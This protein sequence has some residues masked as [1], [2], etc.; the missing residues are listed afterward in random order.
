MHYRISAYATMPLQLPCRLCAD[1]ADRLVGSL[2][3]E[4]AYESIRTVF[5]QATSADLAIF[6][7]KNHRWQRLAG[8][9]NAVRE[10]EWQNLLKEWQALL[11]KVDDIPPVVTPIGEGANATAIWVADDEPMVVMLEHDWSH[12][13]QALET[14]AKIIELAIRRIR[15]E[16]RGRR[17]QRIVK[18]ALKLTR[19][20]AATRDQGLLAQNI[21]DRVATM[22]NA[23]RVSIA[24]FSPEE[25]AL[26]IVAA[27]GI[28]DE[29]VARIRIKPGEWAL[30][31]AYATSKVMAI[32]DVRLLPSR[33]PLRARYKTHSFAAIPLMFG[34][35]TLGVMCITDRR[36]GET[37]L[38]TERATLRLIGMTAGAALAAAGAH[39]SIQQLEHKA[40]IDSVT[41]LFN[42]GHLDTRLLEEVERSQRERTQLAVL[43]ADIDDF[44]AINDTFGHQTGDTVLKQVG[45]IIR[46]AVRMFDVCARFGGDE[47]A[48]LMP[49][50][51]RASAF[52]CA[53]RIRKIAAQYANPNNPSFP[54][55]TM[56][57]GVAVG[58]AQDG[59]AALVARADRAL[60]Q[61][62]AAGKNAVR[63]AQEQEEWPTPV[64]TEDVPTDSTSGTPHLQLPYMLVADPAG[65]RQEIY[66]TVARQHRLGLLIARDAHQA[67]RLIHQFGPPILLIAD[68]GSPDMLYLALHTISQK[69]REAQV[70]AF[71]STRDV[72]DFFRAAPNAGRIQVVNRSAANAVVQAVLTRVLSGV[73]E[74]AKETSPAATDDPWRAQAVEL[75]ARAGP[76]LDVAGAAA[77][78]KDP[79]TGK[80]RAVVR[81][82]GESNLDRCQYFLPRAV[83]HVF[84]RGEAVTLGDV[85]PT[86]PD[87]DRGQRYA[88]GHA[89]MAA[90]IR[91]A[92]EVVAVVS[93]FDDVALQVSDESRRSFEE[94]VA[95]AAAGLA[96]G[97][98]TAGDTPAERPP[99]NPRPH[100]PAVEPA[101][102]RVERRMPSPEAPPT[103]LE[104]Q[105]GEFEVA[106]ELARS[107]REQ[108]QMSVVLF[109]ISQRLK[110]QRDAAAESATESVLQNVVDAFVRTVRQS[111]LP[112]RWSG[113]ELLLVL[114]GVAGVEARAVAER[115]RAAM[116]AGGRRQLLVSGGVAEL[117]RDEQLGTVV[118]RARAKV[119]ESLERGENRV[120]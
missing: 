36:D 90:P 51:D 105:R 93:V 85:A 44:K 109:D 14:C 99:E 96:T 2:T 100:P 70:V 19:D 8:R 101:M 21:V 87:A 9:T 112:I 4:S 40:S 38:P 59:A 86:R 79:A 27:R 94:T 80:M 17:A 24:L 29:V 82:T 98:R 54:Q 16:Q 52:A 71:S 66:T 88:G 39:Q 117:E 3:I 61:A 11:T 103:L 13:S 10:M 83:D 118:E 91:N 69:E 114:P 108:R 104:R 33:S 72:R 32:T 62:K 12:E 75:A 92:D 30:G 53:D 28:P 45:E 58:G 57:V 25:Q 73:A 41:G 26:K 20:R 116:E 68:L 48:V 5:Q 22:F 31:H 46:S 23:E 74:V 76:F 18:P 15:A 113:N 7:R 37:F 97:R 47:F 111:D 56:S 81:W 120:S 119:A 50:S 43:I 60:Y 67:L 115:V 49:N 106:R 55:L 64:G 6:V 95:K 110:Q 1:V 77:Y 89:L 65:P 35:E 42:R 34:S 78:W 63:G 102:P 107:R 84:K